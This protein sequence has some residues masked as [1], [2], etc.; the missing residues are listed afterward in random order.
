MTLETEIAKLRAHNSDFLD[1]KRIQDLDDLLWD[2]KSEIASFKELLEQNSKQ[3]LLLR[4]TVGKFKNYLLIL[5]SITS[6]K[7][8]NIA[9]LTRRN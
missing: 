5:A 1:G 2:M 7:P 6:K 9:P 8:E 3:I 4:A